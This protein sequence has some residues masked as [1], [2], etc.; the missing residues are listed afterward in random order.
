MPSPDIGWPRRLSGASEFFGAPQAAADAAGQP[1]DL[2]YTPG[3]TY[4]VSLSARF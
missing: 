2:S 1:V 3:R 4:G